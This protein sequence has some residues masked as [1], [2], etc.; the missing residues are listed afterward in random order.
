MAPPYGMNPM[1]PATWRLG[2]A[3]PSIFS[4]S[5]S[6][7]MVNLSPSQ[8]HWSCYAI[9]WMP[10]GAKNIQVAVL[11][12]LELRNIVNILRPLLE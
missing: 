3:S 2:Q 7:G 6:N 8:H 5:S 12:N 4:V 1:S 11:L 9:G 10:N